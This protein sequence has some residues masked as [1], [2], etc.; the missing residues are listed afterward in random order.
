MPQLGQPKRA[1]LEESSKGAVAAAEKF[2]VIQSETVRE[3]ARFFER[4]AVLSGSSIALSLTFLG[5]VQSRPEAQ[6]HHPRLIYTSWFFLLGCLV[7]AL[8]RNLKHQ[9]YIYYDGAA[10]YLER[11]ADHV[12][13]E[14]SLIRDSTQFILSSE[15]AIMAEEERQDFAGKLGTKAEHLRKEARRS[16]RGAS[17]A[18]ITW[19]LCEYASEALFFVGILLLVIFAVMNTG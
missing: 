13:S 3:R 4:L 18:E 11:R 15:G 6:L 16:R 8:L 14:V 5:Y 9:D 7:T 19:R 10:S 2:A 17:V 1:H 12:S